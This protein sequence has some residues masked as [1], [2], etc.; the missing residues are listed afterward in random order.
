MIKGILYIVQLLLLLVTPFLTMA[1]IIGLS[2]KISNPNF[3]N[4][5]TSEYV[6]I[7]IILIGIIISDIYFLKNRVNRE[8]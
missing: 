4:L 5:P 1:Y 3:K 7:G 8:K 2:K 6:I